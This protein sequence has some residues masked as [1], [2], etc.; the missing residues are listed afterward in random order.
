MTSV[1]NRLQFQS[2]ST[3]GE[4]EHKC[5]EENYLRNPYGLTI[6]GFTRILLSNGS[7]MTWKEPKSQLVVCPNSLGVLGGFDSHLLLD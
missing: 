3:D 7:K 1:K 6:F 4:T 2:G 5:E